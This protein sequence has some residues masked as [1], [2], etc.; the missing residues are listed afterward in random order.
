VTPI[1]TKKQIA[2]DRVAQNARD[3]SGLGR[4]IAPHICAFAQ[5]DFYNPNPGRKSWS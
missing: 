3:Y 2:P 1:M 4:R 5:L